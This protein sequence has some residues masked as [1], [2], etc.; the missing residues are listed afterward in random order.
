MAV[1]GTV[2]VLH[3]VTERTLFEQKLQYQSLHDALTGLPNRKLLVAN[4]ERLLAL[5]RQ[6]GG[7]VA[8]LVVDLDDF[9]SVNDS[10]GHAAG[11]ELL[12]A[13]AGRLQRT[14]RPPAVVG[15]IGGDEFVVLL[16]SVS[17]SGG[18]ELVADRLRDVLRVPFSVAGRSYSMSASVGIA[19]SCVFA[20]SELLR[21][22]D[23]AMHRAK[24]LGKDRW[25]L[26]EPSM[27]VAAYD[28][29]ELLAD[30]REAAARGEL[31]VAY[32]PTVELSGL[33][34]RGMEALVR[35]DHPVRGRLA[36]SVF[37]PLA[38]ESGLIV[39]IG[40]FVLGEACRAAARLQQPDA[41]LEV[42]VNV[43]IRQLDSAEFV[44]DVRRALASSGL[45]PHLLVLELTE[46]MLVRDPE[47]VIGR[48]ED[49][50]QLGVRIAIDDFGTGY[51]SLSYLRRFPIDVLKIDQTFVASLPG[52]PEAIAVV[53]ALV[54]LGKGLGLELVAEGIELPGQLEVLKAEGCDI[55]QGYLF[56][57]PCEGTLLDE[58]ATH[59]VRARSGEA[60]GATAALAL[61]PR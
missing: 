29:L 39:E 26:F 7:T 12:L 9:K 54:Q 36:P 35:W 31:S 60:N 47:V 27:H 3:D 11:D 30:L 24:L 2:V 41:P 53:R 45:D 5:A 57:R 16:D 44:D 21:D 20:A 40:E 42:A 61:E 52:C 46:S 56:A 49:L 58:Q 48:I 32:Q 14:I 50:K 34:V 13:V 19:N 15:R 33:A 25:A 10:L 18:A 17:A 38:E 6:R 28:R 1:L 4:A 8:A 51:S 55:G 23:A 22:A 59:W 37:V 43:S